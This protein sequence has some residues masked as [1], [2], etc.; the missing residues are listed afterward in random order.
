VKRLLQAVTPLVILALGVLVVM[1]LVRTKPQPLREPREETGVL[2]EIEVAEARAHQ[3]EVRA[4]GTVTPAR[5]VALTPEIAGRVVWVSDALVPG[6]RLEAGELMVRL[7]ARDH[8]LAVRQQLAEV[9]R[10]RM[11]LEIERG[12]GAVAEREWQLFADDGDGE[13]E[14][15]LALRQPQLR[16]AEAAVAAAESGLE[17]ARLNVQRTRLHA[18]LNAL[19]MDRSVDIGQYVGPTAPVATLVGTDE[20]WVRVSIPAAQLDWIDVPGVGGVAEGEGARARVIERV[21]S[22]ARIREGRVIKLLGDVD[23]AG[24]MARVLVALEDPLGLREVGETVRPLLAGSYVEVEIL[25]KQVA[26]AVS[27]P[28]IALRDGDQVFVMDASERLE[29]RDATVAWRDRDTVLVVGGVRDGDRVVVSPVPAPSAGMK[30]RQRDDS[31]DLART[32]EPG[33]AREGSG[34]AGDARA[35]GAGADGSRGAASRA[36]PR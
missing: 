22:A 26:S 16:T 11:E 33:D 19:V 4:S 36:E 32:D 17:R 14:G 20:F 12:R 35:G 7:D 3:V 13:A 29:I 18:P 24:R 28:R 8:E 5:Q 25:A 30:L 10:A 31:G 6:G 34:P 15:A 27:L 23:P 9:D 1:L 2:V 21:G